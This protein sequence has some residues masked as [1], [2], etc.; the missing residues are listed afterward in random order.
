MILPVLLA[1]TLAGAGAAGA[2]EPA[3]TDEDLYRMSHLIYG[4]AGN[5]SR[6]MMEAVGSV[7]LNRVEDDR[8]PGTI[9]DVIFQPGQY[10][11]TWDGNYDLAPS[12]EAIEVARFLLEEGSQIDGSVVWQAEF[13]QGDGIYKTVTSPWGTTMYFCY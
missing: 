3:Y 9:A 2:Q 8:F 12:E 1:A 4:E 11:C 7:V 5:C 13:V 10:S 6:E